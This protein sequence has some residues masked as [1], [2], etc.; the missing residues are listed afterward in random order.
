M[1]SRSAHTD[2]TTSPPPAAD[3]AVVAEIE[4]HGAWS[5]SLGTEITRRLREHLAA[6]PAALIVDLHHLLDPD[7]ASVPLWLAARRTTSVLRPP[8]QLALC[9]PATT[10]LE[11]RLHRLSPHRLPIFTT[12]PQ[13]RTAIADRLTHTPPATGPAEGQAPSHPWIS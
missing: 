7:A 6:R 5:R 3:T 8:V 1:P 12:M 10:P 4:V 9:L 2:P 11:Q 13:A